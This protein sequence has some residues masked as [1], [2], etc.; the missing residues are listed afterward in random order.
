MNLKYVCVG[1]YQ[2]I[3]FSRAPALS[4]LTTKLRKSRTA[5]LASALE[6]KLIDVEI[7]DNA[8]VY[9]IAVSSP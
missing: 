7:L 9:D 3:S 1:K 5:T 8:N 6:Q 4:L 2:R